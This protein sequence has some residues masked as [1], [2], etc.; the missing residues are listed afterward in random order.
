MTINA[1]PTAGGIPFSSVLVPNNVTPVALAGGPKFTDSQSNDVA[2]VGTAPADGYKATYA[3]AMTGLV[4]VTGCTDLFTITG[5]ATK[6]VKVTRIGL[7]G[8]TIT[9]PIQVVVQIIKRSTA[10][11]AGTSSAP[12]NLVTYDSTLNA[13]AT[14]TVLGYTANPTLGTTAGILL[15]TKILFVIAP[16]ATL[17]TY[18]EKFVHEFGIRPSQCPTLRGTT[19]VLAINLGG[20][21]LG[22]ACS[23]DVFVEW[24]EE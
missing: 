24:T 5:S 11:S 19:Q 17:L 18:T 3:A 12:T 4:P 22:T 1:A 16:T 10:N 21:T 23:C 14:A 6:I 15:S 13:A 7:V 20:T 8:T 2:P 9:T